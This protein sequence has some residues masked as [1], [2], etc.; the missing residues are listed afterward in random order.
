MLVTK[1]SKTYHRD[2][3]N[4][5]GRVHTFF[6]SSDK[7]DDFVFFLP[8]LP[9]PVSFE[10]VFCSGIVV[11]SGELLWD[12]MVNVIL[13]L[14]VVVTWTAISTQLHKVFSQSFEFRQYKGSLDSKSVCSRVKTHMRFLSATFFFLSL[15][16]V[17]V[18]QERS[19]KKKKHSCINQNVFFKCWN[20][21]LSFC[22]FCLNKQV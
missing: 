9:D 20:I 19:K 7:T 22:N 12:D 13:R 8:C 10:V 18:G 11:V 17:F 1:Q 5:L 3:T 21:I 2:K 6:C 4:Q 14:L 16:I 15:I